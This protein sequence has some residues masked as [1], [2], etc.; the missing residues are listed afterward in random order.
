MKKV[1]RLL[2]SIG[3]LMAAFYVLDWQAL[4]SALKDLDPW[5]L[6]A[7]TLIMLAEFPIMAWICSSTVTPRAQNASVVRKDGSTQSPGRNP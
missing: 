1:L 6:L 3:L 5:L 2:V 7:V 4:L